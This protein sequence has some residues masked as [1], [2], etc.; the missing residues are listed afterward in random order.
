MT[1]L[2]T[3]AAKAI[4]LLG[5]ERDSEEFRTGSHRLA[6]FAAAIGDPVSLHREGR[7]APPTFAHIPVMQSMVEVMAF[8]T[9]DFALH[10][11]HDYW[12]HAPIVPGLRLL[13][14]SRLTGVRTNAA[15]LLLHITSDTATHTGEAICTQVSTVLVTGRA[16]P[17]TAGEAPA[18]PEAAKGPEVRDSLAISPALT[19]AYAEAARDYSAYCLDA[20][21]AADLGFPAPIVHGMLTLSLAAT[22]I[23]ADFAGGQAGRLRRLGC[24]FAQP[25]FSRDGVALHITRAIDAQGLVAFSATDG[26]GRAVLTRGYAEIAP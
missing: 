15:G 23:V 25:L 26:A 10:G 7:V 8:V 19:L 16:D 13:S 9:G 12:F 5:T 14:R 4:G 18:R 1:D 6:Q 11:E 22:A 20:D 2:N 17:V 24:R 3:L 21:A